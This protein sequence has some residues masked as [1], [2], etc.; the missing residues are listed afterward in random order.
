MSN[1]R[2]L[3]LHRIFL[4]FFLIILCCFAFAF[5]DNLK[6]FTVLI[7][8]SVWLKAIV[9]IY[10]AIAVLLREVFSTER[11]RRHG[12]IVSHFSEYADTLFG[13]GTFVF[14]STTSLSLINGLYL[15]LFYSKT[16]FI[17]FG[18]FDL[19]SMFVVSSFLLFYCLYNSTIMIIS[20]VYLTDGETVNQ[21]EDSSLR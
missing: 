11:T 5:R 6:D 9:C 12:L 3:V 1:Q 10:C 8:S 14:A 13:I 16:Y 4:L 18:N 19:L 2:R 17:G 20:T 21:V 15:Q 7:L